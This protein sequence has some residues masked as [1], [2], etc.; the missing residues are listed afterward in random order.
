MPQAAV[1][2]PATQVSAGVVH[3]V[4]HVPQLALSTSVFTQV[5]MQSVR[6]LGHSQ[7]PSAHICPAGQAVPHMPQFAA[8]VITFTQT[9]PQSVVSV[10]HAQAPEEQLCPAGQAMPHMPQ[11]SGEAMRSTQIVRMPMPIMSMTSQALS[12]L[13][14]ADT[15][16]PP[17]HISSAA[18]IV[19]QAPQLPLSVLVSVQVAPQRSWPAGHI[20]G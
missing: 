18:H 19:P 14:H 5:P 15:Q 13:G 17:V 1:Q 10:G 11:C 12:P 7:E 20:S 3:V 2:L 4:V 8:S 6:P 16:L 9:P